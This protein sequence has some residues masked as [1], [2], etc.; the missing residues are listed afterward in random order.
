M[1]KR[2]ADTNRERIRS[3]VDNIDSI[4]VI[5]SH[6]AMPEQFADLDRPRRQRYWDYPTTTTIADLL[7]SDDRGPE[8][9][10]PDYRVKHWPQDLETFLV[11]LD[12]QWRP[13]VEE[14]AQSAIDWNVTASI[15]VRMANACVGI[16]TVDGRRG[17]QLCWEP[18]R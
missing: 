16:L 13:A 11:D 14:V 6:A 5:Q 17:P 2:I 3:I 9:T 1:A 7:A 18:R 10:R 4:A 15:V 12:D 8:P